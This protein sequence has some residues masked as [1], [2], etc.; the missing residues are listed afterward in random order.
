MSEALHEY[1]KTTFGSELDVILSD[2]QRLRM[3]HSMMAFTFA[4]R[5]EKDDLFI[6]ETKK[7][8]IINFSLVRDVMYKYSKKSQENFF[9]SIFETF[10]FLNFATSAAFIKQIEKKKD[11]TEFKRERLNK[12]NRQLIAVGTK[13]MKDMA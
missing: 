10:Y 9:G 4:H 12:E 5:H 3:I 1:L 6:T 7:D 11:I 2:D 13:A 8:G